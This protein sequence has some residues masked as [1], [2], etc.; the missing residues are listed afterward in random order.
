[1]IELPVSHP[2]IQH[3]FD[4]H[5]PNPSVLWSVLLGRNSGRALVDNIEKPAQCVLRTDTA[6]TYHSPKTSQ[7]FLN[8]AIEYYRRSGSVWLVWSGT[9]SLQPPERDKA[10]IVQRLAFL[11]VDPHSEEILRWQRRLPTGFEIRKID[12]I[13]IEKCDWRDEMAYYCGSI[14]NFLVNGLGLCLTKGEQIVSEGYASSLGKSYAEI[15]AVTREKSRGQGF[16]PIVCAYLI[17]ECNLRGFQA[18]WSCDIDNSA[19][20]RVA[21]KLGFRNSYR[22]IIYEYDPET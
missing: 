7:S 11:N 17:D 10:Q 20:V 16:A 9:S 5:L 22:Y 2:T 15:G 21:Q 13:L 6:L 19:S 1:M 4:T 18:Y 3:L 14:D 8:D 12:H